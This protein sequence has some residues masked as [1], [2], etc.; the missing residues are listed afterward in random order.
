M[1]KMLRKW[2]LLGTKVVLSAGL[3]LSVGLGS[4][5]LAASSSDQAQMM[6]SPK[7]LARF[8]AYMRNI[9]PVYYPA[10]PFGWEVKI[11]D[12]T[13]SYIRKN[14][15]DDAS[16]TSDALGNDPDTTIRMYYTRKTL[17]KN[18]AAF[19]DDYVAK[20]GC[21]AKSKQGTGFYTTSCRNT[22]TY[23]IVIGEKDNLYR[24]ELIGNYNTA[25]RTIIEHYV[26]NIVNGKKVFANRNIGDMT[27]RD[28][29]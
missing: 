27:D 3:A 29:K 20:N 13:V 5:A 7:E 24:I 26:G 21:E 11:E 1:D 18:A 15:D 2:G 22:N 6:P 4:C 8:N 12:N 16:R 28:G 19:M 10:V 17:G 23:A 9:V 14:S 25:A